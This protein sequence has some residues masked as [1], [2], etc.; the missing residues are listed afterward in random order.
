MRKRDRERLRLR[1]AGGELGLV[2]R[3]PD[4]AYLDTHLWVPKSIDPYV[5]SKLKRKYRF[6]TPD[7]DSGQPVFIN[8][9]KEAPEHLIVPRTAVVEGLE[10][11]D[12]RPIPKTI[13]PRGRIKLDWKGGYKQS[14]SVEAWMESDGGVLNL[15]C[16]SG[17]T[18]IGLEVVA[19]KKVPTLIVVHTK[20]LFDQWL[21]RINEFLE[22]LSVGKI[23]GS[24]RRWTWNKDIVVSMLPSLYLHLQS[25]TPEIR[26]HP[27]MVIF[28]EVHRLP[29]EEYGTLADIFPGERYGLTATTR[30]ADN[31]QSVT[32]AHLGPVFF[33]DL[34]QE[35]SPTIYFQLVNFFINFRDPAV[36]NQIRDVRGQINVG[37]LRTFIGAH[38]E[39][40]EWIARY[41]LW[42]KKL[43]RR[44]IVL[45][46]SADQVYLLR[47]LLIE[48]GFEDFGVCTGREGTAGRTDIIDRYDLII[49]TAQIAGEG[50]DKQEL[51]T[52]LLLSPF[53]QEIAGENALQQSMG[54]ILRSV[55]GK[56][57]V[58]I[59]LHDVSI[60]KFHQSCLGMARILQYWSEE[61][62]GALD[63]KYVEFEK[64]PPIPR[65]ARY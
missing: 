1:R 54:R 37:K 62:G 27:G 28:D 6:L 25:L 20:V 65:G 61:K 19:R 57:P 33:S 48:K 5:I 49:G 42:M 50:L 43:G 45:T 8:L 46:H 10:P 56:E 55:K 7:F 26:I 64:R 59:F 35:I 15:S 4:T 9:W 2:P 12:L 16:G 44:P 24:P 40:N 60:P 34:L 21:E 17:K 23:Q 30:R 63:Y 18:V 3:L 11:I 58:V 36:Q 39:R 22:G 13:N 52:L 38:Q 47:D 31:R 41:I 29:S 32:A 51:D 14:K 53:G